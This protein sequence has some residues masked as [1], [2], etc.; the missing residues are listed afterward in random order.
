MDYPGGPNAITWA[1]KSRR[2][3]QKGQLESWSWRA[4]EKFTK[5]DR[6]LTHGSWKVVFGGKKRHRWPLGA[7]TSIQLTANKEIG[8]PSYSCKELNSAN[9]LNNLGSRFSS[10]AV[11]KHWFLLIETVSSWAHQLLTYKTVSS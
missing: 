5:H 6:A 4:S 3:K 8:P 11:S 1:L 10:R 7:K 2:G 9:D